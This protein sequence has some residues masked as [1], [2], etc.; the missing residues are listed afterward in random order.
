MI[1]WINGAFGAGKTETSIELQKRIPNSFIFDPENTGFFIRENIPKEISLGDFQRYSMWCEFN[2][3]ML[4]Y[5]SNEYSGPIIV[6]MTL[7]DLLLFEE[8][9]GRLR[10][11]GVTVHHFTLC[12]SK[13]TLKKRL[14]GRGEIENSWA[15][16]QIDRC[17]E[18]LSKDV[19][20][21]QLDTNHVPIEATVDV[22]LSM[23]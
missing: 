3:S 7:V 10:S 4:S 8:I 23:I 5:I 22:I 17:L 18:G 2:Y 21:H 13:E 1:I 16:Q 14:R 15:E 11:D 6:P 12:A 9:I 20:R 19:F